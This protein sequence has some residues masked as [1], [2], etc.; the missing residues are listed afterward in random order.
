MC[1]QF[2]SHFIRKLLFLQ[3]SR[4]MGDRSGGREP[5]GASLKKSKK[6]PGAPAAKIKKA[7]KSINTT[8]SIGSLPAP[9]PGNEQFFDCGV[10]LLSRQ[11]DRDRDRVVTRAK[12]EGSC[13]GILMW[14]SDIEKQNQISEFCKLNSGFC[15]YATGIHPDNIDKTNKKSH[16]EWADN[17][18][19]LS[20]K[21]E[22]VAILSGKYYY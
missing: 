11:F 21:S 22:C 19:E 1:V 9:I 6:N 20:R 17:I 3:S 2:S 4:K 7:A 13:C 15:Y 5:K 16:D 12:V 10:A 14:F 8:L 18:E